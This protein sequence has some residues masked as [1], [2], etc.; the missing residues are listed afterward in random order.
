MIPEYLREVALMNVP[1]CT[2]LGYRADQQGHQRGDAQAAVFW[3]TI[4]TL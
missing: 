2:P 3:N 4:D 1:G